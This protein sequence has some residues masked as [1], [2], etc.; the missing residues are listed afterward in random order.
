MLICGRN[1]VKLLCTI[2]ILNFCYSIVDDCVV[3]NT[4]APLLRTVLVE[5]NYGDFVQKTYIHP[6]YLPIS[7]NRINDIEISLRDDLGN[8][9]PFEFGKVLVKLHFRRKRILF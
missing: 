4:V 1:T 9:I 6:H 5:G 8:L 2:S 7:Y 3:G